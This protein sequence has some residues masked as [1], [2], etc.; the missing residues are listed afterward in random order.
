MLGEKP[1]SQQSALPQSVTS[2]DKR[3]LNGA[4][5]TPEPLAHAMVS[6]ALS[7]GLGTVLDPSFGKGVFLRAAQRVLNANGDPDPSR[8]IFGVDIDPE[9]ALQ[10]RDALRLSPDSV[11][12]ADFLAL[13]PPQVPGAPFQAVVGNPPFVRHHWLQ[14]PVPPHDDAS[15]TAEAVPLSGRSSSWAHFVRRSLRFLAPGGRLAMVVPEALVQ[16]DYG[17]TV[18]Q[19]LRARFSSVRLIRIGERLFRGTDEVAMV[20]LA[21]GTGP[22]DVLIRCVDR[23]QDAV[24]AL[25]FRGREGVLLAPA[26]SYRAALATQLPAVLEKWQECCDNVVALGELVQIRIGIVTGANRFFVLRPSEAEALGLPKAGLYHVLARTSWLAGLDVSNSDVE[27]IGRL[28][29][30]SLLV[31]LGGRSLDAPA[32]RAWVERGEELGIHKRHKCSKRVPWCSVPVGPVPDAFMTCSRAGAPRIVANSSK[33]RA[34]NA[35]HVLRVR[36]GL[37]ADQLAAA[38]LTTLTAA[39]AELHGRWYGGG[40]LKVEPGLAKALPIPLVTLTEDERRHIA[41]LLREGDEVSARV[42]A[43]D[44]I[45]RKRFGMSEQELAVLQDETALLRAA[46]TRKELQA[47]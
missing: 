2:V 31:S 47:V 1:V 39:Y 26:G 32:V 13:E 36:E 24:G 17:D 14:L 22:G 38:A 34:T 6:W 25:G 19:L 46:R 41:S 44:L 45:L 42:L 28:D 43:D 15:D 9:C 7:A 27:R 8:R 21:E 5:Y 30:P 3:R 29:L 12:T 33:V 40:V 18:L 11:L 16:T 23:L 35:L 10:V 37:R 20:L 4:Y